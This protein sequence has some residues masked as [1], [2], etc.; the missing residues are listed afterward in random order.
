MDWVRWFFTSRRL[1][2]ALAC[3]ILYATLLRTPPTMM[4]PQLSDKAYHVLAFAILVGPRSYR[5]PERW[6]RYALLAFAL[7]AVI[8]VIQPSFGRQMEAADQVANT[9]GIFVGIALARL[10]KVLRAR[11]S[12]RPTLGRAEISDDP[13]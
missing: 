3:V 6:W 9:A 13:S 11:R 4:G 10:A 7:G 8:E 12:T 2:I 5:R 1:T